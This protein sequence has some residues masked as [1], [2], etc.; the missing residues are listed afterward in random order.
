VTSGI[1]SALLFLQNAAIA[2]TA[3]VIQY[4]NAIH[5]SSADIGIDGYEIYSPTTVQS[6]LPLPKIWCGGWMTKAEMP[7][8][9]IYVAD[10]DSKGRAKNPKPIE[11]RNP[12]FPKG[13]I[14]DYSI[15]DP[16]IVLG[17]DPHT[18]I[19]F[20]YFTALC[21]DYLYGCAKE[22]GVKPPAKP[23]VNQMFKRNWVGGAKSFDEGKTWVYMGIILS[24]NNGCDGSGAWSPSALVV[25]DQIWLYYHNNAYNCDDL[26]CTTQAQTG[27]V[28]MRSR[29]KGNGRELDKTERLVD[30][31]G[32]PI[33]GVSNVDVQYAFGK[34]WLAGNVFLPGTP[35]KTSLVLYF[36]TDGIN[37]KPYNGTDGVII[38]PNDFQF[39]TPHIVPTCS[40]AFDMHFGFAK[41]FFTFGQ[42]THLG[43]WS[44]RL[45][46]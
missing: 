31:R 13:H 28:L 46:P 33:A 43:K 37:F 45:N 12:G 39:I 14:P 17:P 2:Q 29:L 27:S 38:K 20:M 11:W 24:Q 9:K 19:Y 18:P 7:A 23:E 35:V 16:T 36:S 6:G 30:P 32:K 44:F 1:V 34:F 21:S 8:D 3:P 41:D 4:R 15:N 40:D 42:G 25:K 5:Q 26:L 22:L 10:Y